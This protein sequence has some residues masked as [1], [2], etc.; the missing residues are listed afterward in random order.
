MIN[1]GKTFIASKT[2]NF[3]DLGT[4]KD[5]TYYN[6]LFKIFVINFTELLKNLHY[7]DQDHNLFK[8]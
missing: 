7:E 2:E 6:N 3:I 4:E 1:E 8:K 5:L